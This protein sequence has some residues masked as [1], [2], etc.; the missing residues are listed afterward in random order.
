VAGG[1]PGGAPAE[2]AGGPAAATWTGVQPAVERPTAGAPA[3]PP[4]TAAGPPPGGA[5][6]G[7]TGG[8]KGP[9]V[10]V[11]VLLVAAL[12]AGAF[13][14]FGGDDDDETADDTTTTTEAEETTT[15]TEAEETTTTTEAEE[16]T[17]TG[18]PGIEFVALTD[19]TGQL[20]V[21][22]PADWTDVSLA[23]EDLADLANI[24][25]STDLAAFRAGF[26]VPGMSFSLLPVPPP[27]GD[28][29]QVLDFLAASVNL[30]NNCV[31]TGKED[32]SDG[33]FTGRFEVWEQC[34]GIGTQIVLVV[35]SQPDGRSI[36]INVQLP[37]GEP[38]E[39]A[40]H[41]AETFFIVG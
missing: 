1:A 28:F 4:P 39:I 29:D 12:G 40:T 25:A 19:A 33:L 11:V 36:E 21:E 35:A 9:L 24:Q 10:A 8:G 23:L 30:Q 20:T 18:V 34:A 5:A 22:V 17:T 26:E 3:V 41:I 37:A 6:A 16:T 38:I 32:Y 14:L 2:T 31:S 13:F 7:G 15:T 27:N